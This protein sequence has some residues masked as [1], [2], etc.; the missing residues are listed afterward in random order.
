M[1]TVLA[2]I[3][4]GEHD[5]L[6]QFTESRMQTYAA[7]IG[8]EY[9][10][11]RDSS[12][13]PHFAKYELLQQV[14]RE[15]F[16]RLLYLDVDVYVKVNS[17]NI[18]DF[19]HS[20]AANEYP[21]PDPRQ[22]SQAT[23]WIRTHLDPQWPT[24]CYFNTG[25]LVIAGDELEQLAWLCGRTQPKPGVYFEQDQLNTLMRSVGFP[26]QQLTAAWNCFCK[27]EWQA[28]HQPQTA[29]FLHT[30]VA[31]TSEKIKLLRE[32]SQQY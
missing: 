29:Y 4:I 3:A 19:Y 5:Q 25:V 22:L 8:A 18:F 9:R 31:S 6:R 28:V 12:S 16:D 7:S 1:N 23:N 20:A 21:H 27:P 13:L 2:T 30:N 32:L 14:V 17:P 10:C 26:K 11:I 15:K 24:D